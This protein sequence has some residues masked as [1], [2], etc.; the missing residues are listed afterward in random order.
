MVHP[1]NPNA[2][3]DLSQ[4]TF[5]NLFVD[6]VYAWEVIPKIKNYIEGY[7]RDGLSSNHHTLTG[8]HPSVAFGNNPIFI[9][10]GTIIEPGVYIEGPAIIGKNCEIR[11]GAYLRSDV[12]IADNAIVG[13]TSE[14]KNAVLLEGAHAPHFAYVGDSILGRNV[15]LGAGTKLS[16]LAVTSFKD[17]IT[18]KRPTVKI[19]YDG[20]ILDTGLAKFGAILGDEVQLGCNCVTNP[21]CIV[22]ARSWVYPA[23]SLIKG[24][25]PSDSIIKL[26]QELIT[27]A[28]RI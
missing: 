20:E 28:K 11:Q 12:I 7:F 27:I 19:E 9:G 13:H 24:Y 4:T 2:L 3:F 26:R 15:N 1:L 21:G 14:V 10:T 25:Y 17:P 8:L 22:G 23:V 6:V 18:T 5:A 16:N